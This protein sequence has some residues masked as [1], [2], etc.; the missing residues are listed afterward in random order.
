MTVTRREFFKTFTSGHH[1]A[2]SS[3]RYVLPQVVVKDG[4]EPYK[5]SLSSP[6]DRTKAAHLLR[7][8]RIGAPNRKGM[9]YP[10]CRMQ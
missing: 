9:A 6:W 7:R 5:P 4:L 10:L 2:L 8:V 3:S 1:N